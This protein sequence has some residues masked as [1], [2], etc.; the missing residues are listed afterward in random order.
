[1]N[2][3]TIETLRSCGVKRISIGIQSFDDI[4]LKDLGR[5]GYKGSE[6]F[7]KVKITSGKFEIVGIDLIFNFPSQ[8]EQSFLN[9][10]EF[11]KSS[12]ADQATFYPIMPGPHKNTAIEKKFRERISQNITGSGKEKH[13]YD[14]IKS[15]VM[16]DGYRPLSVWCFSK[17]QTDIHEYI[18]DNPEYVGIGS[19]SITLLN[20]AVYVNSFSLE[21][22]A[23]YV[24]GGSF[25]VVKYKA[26]T[27][28]EF[29]VYKLLICLFSMGIKKPKNDSLESKEI[30]REILLLRLLG[31]LRA[32]GDLFRVTEKGMYNV[33]V[34][35]EEFL[36]SL[37]D[38]RET[39]IELQI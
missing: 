21:K 13:F 36:R 3:K 33:S 38:L 26:L 19:G 34:M 20:D 14:I 7:E 37:N 29:M 31:T 27:S 32:D 28:H 39:C 1:M 23:E 24:T 17:K 4:L 5:S 15:N 25:P 12:G 2:D 8:T 9:D 10:I 18:V 22:Y 35:M 30:G 11:F 6:A 16:G